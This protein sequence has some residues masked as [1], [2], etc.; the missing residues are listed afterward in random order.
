MEEE[1]TEFY[2]LVNRFGEDELQKLEEESVSNSK[3]KPNSWGINKFFLKERF[4]VICQ[5]TVSPTE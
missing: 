4:I 2:E 1:G 3:K 5:N